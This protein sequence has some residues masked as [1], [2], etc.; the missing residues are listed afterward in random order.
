MSST[1]KDEARKEV[2]AAISNTSS[3][4]MNRMLDAAKSSR[5]KRE[6]SKRERE[7]REAA[8]RERENNASER[9]FSHE[10]QY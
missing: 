5:E 7:A 2:N 10:N 9:I 8:I 4:D 3:N 1:K 6:Q